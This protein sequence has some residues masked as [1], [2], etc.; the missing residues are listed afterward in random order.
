V[1]ILIN[2]SWQVHNPN[3]VLETIVSTDNCSA[4]TIGCGTVAQLE[5]NHISCADP[6]TKQQVEQLEMN[7]KHQIENQAEQIR[8]VEN[9]V[10]E[11]LENQTLENKMDNLMQMVKNNFELMLSK[12]NKN[13][14]KASGNN[15]CL[16]RENGNMCYQYPCYHNYTCCT[17]H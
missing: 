4:T 5:F 16:F 15:N 13:M 2:Y 10:Q 1:E 11:K 6:A 14:L 9:N 8:T 3:T 12:G 7:L 17:N